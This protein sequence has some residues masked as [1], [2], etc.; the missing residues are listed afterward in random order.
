MWHQW[1]FLCKTWDISNINTSSPA[2]H[3]AINFLSALYLSYVSFLFLANLSWHFPFW[4]TV[5][6]RLEGACFLCRDDTC[7]SEMC[8]MLSVDLSILLKTTHYSEQFECAFFYFGGRPHGSGWLVVL[9]WRPDRRVIWPEHART[10]LKATKPV[11]R[12]SHPTRDPTG[13][14]LHTSSLCQ[15]VSWVYGRCKK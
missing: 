3:Q 4:V 14:C 7:S 10:L 2:C 6:W 15:T 11:Y 1:F 9:S 8:V 13:L 5:Q 12:P